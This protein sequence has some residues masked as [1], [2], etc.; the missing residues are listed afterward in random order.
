MNSYSLGILKKEFLS[1]NAKTLMLIK[2]K[3]WP[4]TDLLLKKEIK[5][6]LQKLQYSISDFA[7]KNEIGLALRYIDYF[8]FSTIIR[9]LCIEKVR[10]R[11][12]RST[13]RFNGC[14]IKSFI[15]YKTCFQ[16]FE[17][18]SV[19][20]V[21]FIIKMLVKVMKIPK[22]KLG[23]KRVLVFSNTI[24]L[25]FQ[26]QFVSLL[27]P[28]IDSLISNK[29]YGF[30][31][32][33]NALQAVAYLSKSIQFSDL[34][35][36]Y[37]LKIDI[38]KC[39]NNLKHSYI[40]KSFPFTKKY[41]T[42]LIHWLKYSS[43][44][45]NNK[46]D[47]LRKS[48]H[49]RSIISPLI[50]NFVLSTILNNFFNDKQF[51]K[52][53]KPFN[54]KSNLHSI[55]AKRF[56]I[57][58]ASDLIIKVINANEAGYSFIKLTG[59][60]KIVGLHVNKEKSSIYNLLDKFKF[61]WLGYTFLIIPKVKI[62]SSTSINQ[63]ERGLVLKNKN[64]LI[65]YLSNSNY[66]SIKINLKNIIGLL[67]H[68]ALLPVLRKVNSILQGIARYFSFANN[69]KRLNYLCH[70]VDRC[71]WRVL[72]EKFRCNG[73]RRPRWVSKAFFINTD[74][75]LSK[76]WHLFCS[77]INQNST[78]KQGILKIWCVDVANYYR[79]LPISK[80]LLPKILQN[81][82]YYLDNQWKFEKYDFKI[83]KLRFNFTN[84]SLV[85]KLFKK[86]K[87]I[88]PF[89]ETLIDVSNSENTEIHHVYTL[90][91]CKNNNEKAI[92]KKLI[93]LKLLHSVCHKAVHS[94]E[95]HYSISSLNNGDYFIKFFNSK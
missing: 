41:K 14:I 53:S 70:F 83:Q 85:M 7:N 69:T 21:N 19:K 42:L 38:K 24:D 91:S 4:L 54:L 73:I 17:Q 59:L 93:N 55:K 6:W 52:Y 10:I 2:K 15:D 80:V 74:S 20:N 67:K 62:Y 43:I 76:K 23:K 28:L 26:L 71:F 1:I 61:D 32:G 92:A 63:D 94:K 33:R 44:E 12:S 30:R 47:K 50:F 56:F 86:Q 22:K 11:S 5:V 16:L 72:V 65:L 79:I 13:A 35:E 78:K 64:I 3:I 46:K 8:V 90:N 58:Y 25:V 49:Q 34:T 37:V 57:S 45:Q 88:C 18:S 36:Y 48:I 27:D 68:H 81:C 84:K 39:F 31:K 40:L 95:K 60:L 77:T 89:C 29:F 82:D 9:L 66:K 87:G 75:P 51:F